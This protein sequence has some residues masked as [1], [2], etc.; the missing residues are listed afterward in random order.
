MV[1][2]RAC[3]H[4]GQPVTRR[5]SRGRMPGTCSEECARAR[6]K[7]LRTCDDDAA[8]RLREGQVPHYD[9]D[10]VA[11]A[12]DRGGK[13]PAR[14]MTELGTGASPLARL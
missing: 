12:A 11:A 5:S 6:Q 13:L 2:D 14:P 3:T 8:W 10:P 1:E 7:R 9:V 4:C